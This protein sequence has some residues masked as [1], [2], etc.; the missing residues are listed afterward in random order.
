MTSSPSTSAGPSASPLSSPVPTAS[1]TPTQ[2]ASP[3]LAT[4]TPTVT[5][6]PTPS[7]AF[8]PR[9]QEV[10]SLGSLDAELSQL[11]GFEGGYVLYTA[12]SPRAWFSSD[13]AQWQPVAL[14]RDDAPCVDDEFEGDLIEAGSS[15]PLGIVL[16]GL[17]SVERPGSRSCVQQTIAWTSA[18]GH[19]WQRSAPFGE[20]RYLSEALPVS[21]WPVPDGWQAA[22]GTYQPGQPGEATGIWDSADGLGWT[23]M[24]SVDGF[25]NVLAAADERG[26]TILSL[27]GYLVC[28]ECESVIQVALVTS[29]GTRWTELSAPFTSGSARGVVTQIAP[30]SDQLAVWT[31]W[32]TDPLDTRRQTIWTSEDLVNWD[33]HRRRDFPY[34]DLTPT[35]AGLIATRCRAEACSQ[36][37]SLN[38]SD[39]SAVT[40]DIGGV[41]VADGPAGVLAYSLDNGDV[42][43][44][45]P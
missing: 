11:L 8:A 14:P 30:P 39:W 9:W 13:G 26:K 35:S 7:Q 5:A 24:A 34:A 17:A 4:V 43:R 44:L 38:G 42:F 6:E 21:V 25:G 18:D 31:L 29:D 3:A 41:Q 40:P 15:G 16:L 20:L 33:S 22:I 1:V 28:I 36:Y 19:T 32:T 2:I 45:E 37:I 10:G 12:Y 23:Q 27:V